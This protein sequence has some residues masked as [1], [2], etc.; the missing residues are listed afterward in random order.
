MAEPM[1]AS[2]ERS[3][4]Q[5]LEAL[6]LSLPEPPLPLGRYCSAAQTGSLLLL[7]GVLPLK[8]GR[9]SLTGRVGAEVS[10]AQGRGA[11]RLAALNALSIAKR[12][13]GSLQK[14]KRLI[15]IGVSMTTSP[16]FQ[17]HA[18]VADGASEVFADLFDDLHTRMAYGVH[19]LPLGATVLLEV[20]FETH[21][22]A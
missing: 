13:L 7:S 15:R 11:A 5:R 21:P 2:G 8:E 10:V 17:D 9:P 19:T 3:F 16:D 18:T 14:V 6:G 12:F 20:I 1:R 4:E 22:E